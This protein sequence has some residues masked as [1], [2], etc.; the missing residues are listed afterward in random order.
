MAT[1]R[2]LEDAEFLARCLYET[3][4]AI[5]TVEPPG[6]AWEALPDSYKPWYRDCVASFLTKPFV[7]EKAKALALSR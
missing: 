1:G 7:L 2:R 3:M 4:E 6:P 5:E